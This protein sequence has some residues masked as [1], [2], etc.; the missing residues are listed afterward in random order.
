MTYSTRFGLKERVRVV[1]CK[2]EG[3]II[4]IQIAPGGTTYL[5]RFFME[6]VPVQDW[7]YEDECEAVD[8]EPESRNLSNIV[9]KPP[10]EQPTKEST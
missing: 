9:V 1:P 5:V 6:Q 3:H 2:V 7:F 4:A 10:K 8:I